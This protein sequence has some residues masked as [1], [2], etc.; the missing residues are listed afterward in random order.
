MIIPFTPKLISEEN[1]IIIFISSK[2]TS[3]FGIILLVNATYRKVSSALFCFA[4]TT[5]HN[6]ST[7]VQLAV[8]VRNM[9]KQS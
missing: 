2:E 8:E 7:D 1:A 9:R 5:G 6:Y 3:H 4:L